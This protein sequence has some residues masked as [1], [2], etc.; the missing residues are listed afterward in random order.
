M[1]SASSTMLGR[2]AADRHEGRLEFRG[3]SATSGYFRNAAKTRELFHDGW[4]D[5]GDLAYMA[6]GE[7]FVTG[8]VKDIIIRGGQHIYPQEI[9]DAVSAIPGIDQER[10]RRVRRHRCCRRHRTHDRHGRDRRNRSG[11]ASATPGPHPRGRHGHP[12]RA[13]GRRRAGAAADRSQDVE[14]QDPP[15]RRARS[16]S[17]RPSRPAP[18]TACIANSS[19]WR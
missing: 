13:A 16:L 9:E 7:V 15:R 5:T 10:R 11:A 4:L 12:R 6:G 17:E 14:P 18:T 19:G 2:E 3:P 8:R 1:T